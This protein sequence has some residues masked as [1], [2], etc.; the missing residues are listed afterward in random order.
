MQQLVEDQ[1][2]IDYDHSNAPMLLYAWVDLRQFPFECIDTSD[3]ETMG[4]YRVPSAAYIL[5]QNCSRRNV[6]I[7]D[8]SYLI[9]P[10]LDLKNTVNSFNKISKDF[11]NWN[12]IVSRSPT[13]QEFLDLLRRQVFLYMGH[14]SGS[15]YLPEPLLFEKEVR[16]AALLF[17]CSSA[18]MQH[19]GS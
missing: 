8:L 14:G 12:G 3:Y 6:N 1:R 16:S 19:K 9:N 4:V 11:V 13:H 10:G 2:S 18:K 5:E 17:G 7:N 15:Q